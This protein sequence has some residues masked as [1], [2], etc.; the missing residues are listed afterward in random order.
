MEN[1][2]KIL[3]E[4]MMY[5]GFETII[6]DSFIGSRTG[7]CYY[8]FAYKVKSGV[9]SQRPYIREKIHSALNL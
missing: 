7:E 9:F 3:K 1:I 4:N 8:L 2:K 5:S 6:K